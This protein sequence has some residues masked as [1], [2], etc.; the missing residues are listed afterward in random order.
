MKENETN[1]CGNVKSGA[2]GGGVR[3]IDPDLRSQIVKTVRNVSEAYA[4]FAEA[5]ADAKFQAEEAARV[6]RELR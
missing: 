3:G 1:D 2:L 4:L 6:L 5:L